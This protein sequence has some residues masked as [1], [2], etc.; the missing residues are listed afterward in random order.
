MPNYA[1]MSDPTDMTAYDIVRTVWTRLG[2]PQSALNSLE[3]PPQPRAIKTSFKVGPRAQASLGLSGFSAAL[4]H[5][6]RNSLSRTPKVTADIDGAVLEFASER[7]FSVNGERWKQERSPVGGL[8]RAK[9][10]HVKLGFMMGF[11]TTE[12]VHLLCCASLSMPL[13]KT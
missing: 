13:E 11:R 12:T 4:V 1:I 9:D 7:Y 8:F 6:A 10:G 2:L 5:A 3:L